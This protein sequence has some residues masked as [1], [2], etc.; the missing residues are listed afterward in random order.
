MLIRSVLL[1]LWIN[2]DYFYDLMVSIRQIRVLQLLRRHHCI[3][4]PKEMEL[5]P[6]SMYNYIYS[7]LIQIWSMLNTFPQNQGGFIHSWFSLVTRKITD[8]S[9][10]TAGAPTE[11]WTEH[12]PN[13][14]NRH[15]I[16][17]CPSF[18]LPQQGRK[19]LEKLTEITLSLFSAKPFVF[20]SAV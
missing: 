6:V 12:L 17:L 13:T 1:F 5:E 19:S 14:R 10:R 20:S 18:L 15:V 16:P 4:F 7:L 11:I 8:T 9:F 2:D 3:K